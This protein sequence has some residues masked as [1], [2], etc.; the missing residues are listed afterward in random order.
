LGHGEWSFDPPLGSWFGETSASLIPDLAYEL[1]VGQGPISIYPFAG[2]G[3][4]LMGTDCVQD[5]CDAVSRYQQVRPALRAGLGL[6]YSYAERVDV[7]LEP[8]DVEA[9]NLAGALGTKVFSTTLLGLGW[10]F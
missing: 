2:F 10:K 9:I 6:R 4:W 7:Y 1:R 8:F 5:A 3:V